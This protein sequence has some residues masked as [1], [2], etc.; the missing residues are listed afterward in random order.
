[1]VSKLL[2]NGSKKLTASPN[3]FNYNFYNSIS[4]KKLKRPNKSLQSFDNGLQ[5]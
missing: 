4:Y 1:M 3:K 2:N 5:N